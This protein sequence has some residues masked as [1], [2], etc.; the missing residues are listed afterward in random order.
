MTTAWDE[1]VEGARALRRHW[2]ERVL[3]RALHNACLELCLWE[4]PPGDPEYGKR[5]PGQ[6]ADG[7]VQE[8]CEQLL[9]EL[10]GLEAQGAVQGN[11]G[12]GP[13]GGEL[14]PG[15]SC[16]LDVR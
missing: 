5:T 1:A 16:D 11:P 14:S 3:E 6:V 10:E 2:R 12:E 15:R 8:A 13:G 4:H 7:F 9:V